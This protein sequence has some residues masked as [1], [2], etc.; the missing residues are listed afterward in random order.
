MVMTTSARN[1]DGAW[2]ERN[3]YYV[4]I[5]HT[6]RPHGAQIKSRCG[7]GAGARVKGAQ[8]ILDLYI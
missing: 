2:R 3:G 7:P 5:I 6:Y 1:S 4:N 8:G